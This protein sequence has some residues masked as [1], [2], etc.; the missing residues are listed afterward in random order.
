MSMLI[1]MLQAAPRQSQQRQTSIA[2]TCTALPRGRYRKNAVQCVKCKSQ[3]KQ[4]FT[5]GAA[6][7]LR[8]LPLPGAPIPGLPGF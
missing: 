2:K 7:G 3:R 5:E 8:R 6:E 4:Q 1:S